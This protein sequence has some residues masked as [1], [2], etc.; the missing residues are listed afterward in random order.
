MIEEFEKYIPKELH[1]ISG[2]V[3]HSGRIAFS[4]RRDLYILGHNPG[5]DPKLHTTETVAAHA[6][7]AVSERPD[8]WSEYVDEK[9]SPGGN[10]CAAGEAPM[11]RRMQHLMRRVG[12]DLRE[13]PASDLF[14][15]RSQSVAAIPIAERRRYIDLC[16]PFHEAVISGLGIRVILCLGRDSEPFIK[17]KIGAFCQV[18]EFV[19]IK[20]QHRK[21]ACF[22][23]PDNP[24]GLKVVRVT[25]PSRHHWTH[26]EYDPSE[27]VQR[28]LA[29]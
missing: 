12:L 16:W 3:F 4:G 1:D 23:N 19:E 13:V 7:K 9:W 26:P 20:G 25:H 21:S 27:L 18:D 10:E 15:V 29:D 22:V 6:R 17:R 11:Q 24:S 28:A 14:F 5:G 8:R 2:T